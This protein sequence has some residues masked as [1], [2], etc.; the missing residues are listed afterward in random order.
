MAQ[1]KFLRGTSEQIT[2][3]SVV[4]GQI[5]VATDKGQLFVDAGSSRVQI[6]D[7]IKVATLPE[8]TAAN[9]NKVYYATTPNV[10]AVSNG[11]AWTQINAQQVIAEGSTNGTISVAGVD[12]PVHGLGSAAFTESNAYD[13]AGSAAAVLGD[14]EDTATDN[15][16]Y[17][18]KAAAAAAQT[19]ADN[20]QDAAEAAQTAA[21]AKV[22][23]ITA[24]N[25]SINVDNTTA[26][27]PK[28]N[29]KLSEDEDN[30]LEL[31]ADGLKVATGSAP[32]Y[33]IV[34]DAS[35]AAG[36]FATYHLTKAGANVGEAI[37]IPK[38]Y[39]VKSAEVATVETADD[40]YTGAAVGDKY[41]D[42]TVNTVG[43][44]GTESHLYIAVKDLMTP[45]SAGNGINVSASN[46]ISAKVVAGNGLSVGSDG[47][48]MAV[49]SGSAA[50]AMSSADYTKL[51]GI[52][53]GAEVNYVKSVAAPVVVSGTGELSVPAATT[54]T[55]GLL[56][57][58]DKAHLDAIVA[59]GEGYIT[60]V[61]A[62][63]AVEEG[64]LSIGAASG[65]AAGTMSSADFTK[66]A[67]VAEGA[68]VNV[69]DAITFNGA[70]VN[71][72]GKTAAITLEWTDLA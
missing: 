17:G 32:V 20:A 7:I 25:A 71:V 38:D 45:I 13:A 14:A 42:F 3:A 33:S 23:S 11:T 36:F 55:A 70:T 37:N 35:A 2:S 41:I 21:D 51:Q 9:I 22:A 67:G 19:A 6:N 4:D 52:A 47:I 8:A 43:D 56:S 18:A 48:A 10:L 12:V 65:T 1:I 26:T 72:A 58:A 50:G 69:I 44:D 40:P 29:V 39:L 57:A 59:G 46:Q 28:L 27:A 64:E 5:L 68:E 30:V 49:A 16:V 60:S 54:S 62:P 24:A 61:T 31:V 66:L 15:T 53:A 34:K 63:L